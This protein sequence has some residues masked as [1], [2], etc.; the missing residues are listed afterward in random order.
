MR[1]I[2]ARRTNR[3]EAG[4]ALGK[5]H[6]AIGALRGCAVNLGAVRRLAVLQLVSMAVKVIEK[7]GA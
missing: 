1:F 5:R 2:M 4:R 3:R 7:R 6:G